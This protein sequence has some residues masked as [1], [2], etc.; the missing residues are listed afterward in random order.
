MIKGNK[1]SRGGFFGEYCIY[2]KDGKGYIVL[3][4]SFV[5]RH[6][7]TL[8]SDGLSLYHTPILEA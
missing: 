7:K 3:S 6:A 2:E 4:D 1:K 5:K 8:R